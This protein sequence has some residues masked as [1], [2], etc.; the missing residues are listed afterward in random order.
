MRYV[1]RS[2]SHEYITLRMK[3]LRF[4][5]MDCMELL[6]LIPDNYYDWAIVDPPYFSGPEKRGFYGSIN[7][8]EKIKRK[9]Y[10]ISK[11]NWQLPTIEYYNEIVRVSRNQIIWGINYFEFINLVGSGRIIWNK[12]NGTSSFSDCEIASISSMNHVRM[13]TYMWNGMLQGQSVTNGHILQGNV[14]KREKRIHPT[15]KPV[16]LY[17]WLMDKFTKPGN[18]ILDTHG[19]SMSIAIAAHELNRDIDICEIDSQVFDISI[20][21]VKKHVQQ[22]KL[23]L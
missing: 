3:K 17:A 10:H 9:D 1:L 23:P 22:L 12:V 2:R 21:R 18:K 20:N 19:G 5:N 4:F 15:Q 8:S 7:G 11:D 16:A 14:K 6:R 13:F